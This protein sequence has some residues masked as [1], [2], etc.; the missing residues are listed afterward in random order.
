[1][2]CECHEDIHENTN[3]CLWQLLTD[4]ESEMNGN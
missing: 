4:I 3:E 2:P 1:M